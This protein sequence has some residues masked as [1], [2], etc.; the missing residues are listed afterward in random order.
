LDSVEAG[1]LAEARQGAIARGD[2]ETVALHLRALDPEEQG[3]YSYLG[4][5]MLRLCGGT[6]QADVRD[7]LAELFARHTELETPMGRH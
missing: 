7:A 1:G 5:E 4:A 6:M 3:W 2:Y